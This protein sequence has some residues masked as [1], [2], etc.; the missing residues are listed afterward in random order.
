MARI[1]DRQ[2]GWCKGASGVRAASSSMV[3]FVNF[4][5]TSEIAS[6]VNDAMP[7]GG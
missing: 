7:D 6:A 3:W 2:R 1:G 4:G 5:R